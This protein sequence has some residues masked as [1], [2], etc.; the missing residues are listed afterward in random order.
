M[1][2]APSKGAI[3]PDGIAT[4]TTAQRW[5]LGLA[6]LGV[7]AALLGVFAPLAEVPYYHTPVPIQ[8]DYPSY[9]S[10]VTGI[11]TRD[12]YP[13]SDGKW[14]VFFAFLTLPAFG[15]MAAFRQ[16]RL[17]ALPML[18]VAIGLTVA[19]LAVDVYAEAGG[20]DS[21]TDVIIRNEVAMLVPLAAF[22]TGA[23]SLAWLAGITREA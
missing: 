2:S 9:F 18:A 7:V 4:L 10:D 6:A 23:S 12:N 5:C 21:G 17:S 1:Y 19:F 3:H 20:S 16:W 22:L 13:V 8:V 15:V 14:V 11:D